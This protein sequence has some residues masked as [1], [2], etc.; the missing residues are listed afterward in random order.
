MLTYHIAHPNVFILVRPYE[1]SL[2][3][4]MF[5][6]SFI[7][8]LSE[9]VMLSQ[10]YNKTC[11]PCANIIAAMNDEGVVAYLFEEISCDIG[12]H[13]TTLHESQAKGYS[14]RGAEGSLG[15]L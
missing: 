8:R 12:Y 10:G 13:L 11:T 5:P 4:G 15:L 3:E 9:G 14:T 7:L 6:Q 1:L 2:P